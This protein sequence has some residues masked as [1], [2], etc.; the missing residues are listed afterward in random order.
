MILIYVFCE[1]VRLGTSCGRKGQGQFFK[2]ITVY[3][4]KVN[5]SKSLAHKADLIRSRMI[6]NLYKP[7]VLLDADFEN[8][9][10]ELFINLINPLES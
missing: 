5:V 2:K 6:L 8:E 10:R 4:A 7:P 1:V 9:F 3:R